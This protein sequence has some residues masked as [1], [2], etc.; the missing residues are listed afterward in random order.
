MDYITR[1]LGI[2]QPGYC[3]SQMPTGRKNAVRPV[4]INRP[5]PGMWGNKPV[6]GA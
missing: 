2:E 1:L 6:A 4:L 3:G 5:L